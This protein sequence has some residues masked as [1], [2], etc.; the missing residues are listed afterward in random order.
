MSF[1]VLLLTRL[2]GALKKR[3]MKK[4]RKTASSA[5]KELRW[6]DQI[7]VTEIEVRDHIVPMDVMLG[8]AAALSQ[9]RTKQIDAKPLPT[10][11]RTTAKAALQIRSC[12]LADVGTVIEIL[13]AP[14]AADVRIR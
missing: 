1:A 12:L 14:T 5:E 3:K 9:M 6:I 8:Q 10:E 13:I 2:S 4:P 7:L 11:R